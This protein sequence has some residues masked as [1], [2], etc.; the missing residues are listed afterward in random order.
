M[1]EN[2]GE[3][4]MAVCSS[5]LHWMKETFMKSKCAGTGQ[6]LTRNHEVIN[7]YYLYSQ[8]PHGV[9]Q[10]ANIYLSTQVLSYKIENVSQGYSNKKNKYICGRFVQGNLLLQIA[11]K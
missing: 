3:K 5:V 10:C 9:D 6:S 7:L 8:L 11:W 4:K 1:D 2:T